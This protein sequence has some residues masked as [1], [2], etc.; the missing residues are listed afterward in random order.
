ME[1]GTDPSRRQKLTVAVSS[2]TNSLGNPSHARRGTS[3]GRAR[4]WPARRLGV[5]RRCCGGAIASK[6]HGLR[7][8]IKGMT[9]LGLIL[10]LILLVLLFGGGGFYLG[11]P[12]HLFGGGFGLLLV[13]V[14]VVL[15]VRG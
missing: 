12:F 1:A 14:I 6:V 13:I 11:P 7:L 5:F 3:S 15:L 2:A 9:N 10:F 8:C 4:R